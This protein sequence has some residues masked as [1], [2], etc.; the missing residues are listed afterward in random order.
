MTAIGWNQCNGFGPFG[1]FAV[2]LILLLCYK[3]YASGSKAIDSLGIMCV[4]LHCIRFVDDNNL[5]QTFDNSVTVSA[6]FT[7]MSEYTIQIT[8]GNIA[9]DK[10]F[11]M[12]MKWKWNKGTP[13]LQSIEETPGD[14]IVDDT[15]ITRLQPWQAERHLGLRLP[16]NGSS[17]IEYNYRVQEAKTMGDN[18]YNSSFDHSDAYL[19]YVTRWIPTIRYPLLVTTFSDKQCDDIQKPFIFRLLPKLGLNRHFPRV[20]LYSP[21][22]RGGCGIYDIKVEQL[23]MQMTN[24][25]GHMRRNDDAGKLITSN[26]RMMQVIVGTSTFFMN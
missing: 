9:T 6:M 2:M 25:N 4:I 19:E 15:T 21:I 17:T 26:L 1:W 12:L 11:V 23:S 18:I 13:C 22:D 16:L 14:L 5:V 8:G 3:Q 24:C 20:V 10:S 7:C